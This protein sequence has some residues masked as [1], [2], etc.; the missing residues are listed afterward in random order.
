MIKNLI[1]KQLLFFDGAMGTQ[2][3]KHGLMPGEIPDI[4]NITHADTVRNIHKQYIAAGSDIIKTNTFGCNAANLEGTGYSVGQ[5]TASAIANVKSAAAECVRGKPCFTALDI[6]PTGKLLKPLGDLHFEQAAALFKETV[7]AGAKAGAD[8]ILIET[9]SCAYELKAAVLAAKEN[10]N[11]PVIASVTLDKNGK[12]LTGGGI[13]VVVALLEGLGADV[14]GLNCG[15]GINQL[16]PHITRMIE[17]SSTPVLCMPNAGLPDIINGKIQYNTDPQGFAESMRRIAESGAWLLGGCCGTTPDHIKALVKNCAGLM[18]PETIAKNISVAASYAKTVVFGGK[19]PDRSPIVI[20]E[21]INPT[22][23]P[24]LKQALKNGDYDFALREGIFQTEQGADLLD[25][26]AGMTGI[27]EA[28]VLK[29][30][31]EQLQ[32]IVDVPLQIDT[33]NTDALACVMRAYNG[34]P[35]VNSVNGKIKVMDEVFPLVRKYGGLVVALT[36]DE[37]GIP[38][39]AQGRIDIAKKILKHAEKY[40]IGKK[41]FLFDPLTMAVSAGQENAVVTLECL[42]RLKNELNVKTL[43]GVSNVS[44]GLPAREILNS[45][46]LSLALEAGLDAAIFN[47][48]VQL[49]QQAVADHANGKTVPQNALPHSAAVDAL[50]GRDDQ[51]KR[52]IETYGG[53]QPDDTDTIGE[54]KTNGISLGDAVLKGLK[55]EA[56]QRARCDLKIHS[57]IDLIEQEIIPALNRAGQLFEQGTMFLPQ[58]LM[59]AETAKSAFTL[60]RSAMGSGGDSSDF[61]GTIV[62]ATVEGDIHD[63]GKNIVRALLENYRFHVIDLGK[64][65]PVQDI[66]EAVKKHNAK[67]VGLS[68]LM[69]TT[70]INMERTI[71]ALR[72]GGHED[73]IDCKIMCGGAVLTKEYAE[74]IGADC[75]VKDAM[76]SVRYAQKVFGNI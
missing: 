5:L 70:V 24:K 6:G 54:K 15:S 76:A 60:I 48:G 73:G 44:F 14:I 68:A 53:Q 49:M 2:L 16:L 37:N 4:W 1:G 67:L 17:L 18:L 58:L 26:N 61:I 59:C 30:L 32:G 8:L 42:R 20:G 21:R 51:F 74:Q 64:D 57:P 7:I 75:Y 39:T 28:A 25:V 47:P 69:T 46:F 11:L 45:A 66:V 12:L 40:G 3:Q 34:K 23:K 19:R 50:L 71:K 63:I 65:V 27:D 33:A 41:D 43:L 35:V 36:L 9:M 22:G 10:C 52:Y 72:E 31:I 29:T 62:V 13:D 38:E 55:Q 56:E